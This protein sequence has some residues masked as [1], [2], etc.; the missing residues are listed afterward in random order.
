MASNIEELQKAAKEI[1]FVLD[2]N[3]P[4][5]YDS[6]DDEHLF[7]ELSDGAAE[8]NPEID[9]RNLSQE[10]LDTLWNLGLWEGQEQ[11]VSEKGESQEEYL[12][13]KEPDPEE[14]EELEEE[15]D[16]EQGEQKLEVKDLGEGD[17]IKV[18]KRMDP[19]RRA[20]QA[21]LRVKNAENMLTLRKIS[22]M[23]A[24]EDIFKRLPKVTKFKD[25]YTMKELMYKIIKDFKVA[26]YQRKDYG[27]VRRTFNKHNNQQSKLAKLF[28]QIIDSMDEEGDMT[29][30]EIKTKVKRLADEKGYDIPSRNV[31]RYVSIFLSTTCA[32]GLTRQKHSQKYSK[33]YNGKRGNYE[34]EE[35]SSKDS[36]GNN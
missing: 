21:Y 22:K 4:L 30:P 11:P 14:E 3:P 17:V 24:F 8:I 18:A 15:S 29:S 32:F 31:S 33:L 35:K 10:T 19:I 12:E 25:V 2:L 9:L 16:S 36:S 6:Q 23:K 20:D 34:S 1:Q 13:R 26:E 28:V 27:K 5:E 7:N